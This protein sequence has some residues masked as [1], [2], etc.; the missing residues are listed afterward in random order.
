MNDIFISYA[1]TDRPSAQLF[2]DALKACGWSVWWDRE[3]PLGTSFDQVIEEHLNGARCVIVLWST[4]AIR[5]RWVKTEAASAADRERL[6]LILI[7]DVPIPLEFKRIQT[8]ALQKW[9]GDRDDPEFVRLLDSIKQMLGQPGTPDAPNVS[10][11]HSAPDRRPAKSR[12]LSLAVGGGV[13]V[14]IALA[15]LLTKLN[16]G[17]GNLPKNSQPVQSQQTAST[18]AE[19]AST[20][21]SNVAAHPTKG[22]FSIKIGD[23]IKE[24]MPAPGAG[25]IENPGERDTY[26]FNAAAGQRVYFRMM[27]HGQKMSSI[28][29][30]LTDPDDTE[31]FNTCLSCGDPGVQV[32]RKA[33][34]Y[35]LTVGS[36]T[37]PATGTYRLQLSDVPVSPSFS[38]K[39]GDTIRENMPAPGAGIIERPGEKDIYRFSVAAGQ[40]VYFRMVE[41]GDGM[42]DMKWKLA[43][44]DDSVLFNTCLSCGDPGVRLLRK[45]GDYVLTVGSDTDP[46]TGAYRLQLSDVPVSSSFSIKIGDTI[47]ENMPAPGAGIIEKP[48]EKDIYKFSAAAGQRVY[49]RMLE[50]GNG[51]SG[52][53]WKLTDPDETELFNT[54]FGCGDPGVQL[55]RKAGDYVLTV[56]LDTEPATGTYRLQLASDPG[57]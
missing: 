55:L 53:K 7:E 39:I 51:M 36:D 43:D 10:L 21:I 38:V 31:L 16:S 48:G 54:C 56:G 52:M 50:R 4:A 5:S 22:G 34:D 20:P 25:I 19:L 26:R 47:K 1:N 28:K 13:A 49:F 46:A 12:R 33:G 23:T 42:S 9:Q 27:E 41:R 45:A 15:F 18:N 30:K 40:R 8:A 32:L 35:V 11:T 24:N 6:I 17:H 29:W 14:L 2:A 57:E 37:E 3:I 44:P